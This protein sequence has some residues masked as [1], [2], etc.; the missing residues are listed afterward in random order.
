VALVA[1]AGTT[2]LMDH[3]VGDAFARIAVGIASLPFTEAFFRGILCNALVCLGVW[4]ALAGRS[5][6]DKAVGIVFP[7]TAFVACGFEHCIANMFSS[8]W[9]WSR[10]VSPSP[11]STA[12]FRT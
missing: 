3:G 1:G 10:V 9:V 6:M 4:L 5:V 12:C 11:A 2:D 7:I 8:R